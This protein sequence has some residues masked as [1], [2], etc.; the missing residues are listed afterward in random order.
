MKKI[1][2]LLL[3][4]L[5]LAAC[6]GTAENSQNVY[7]FI[8]ADLPANDPATALPSGGTVDLALQWGESWTATCSQD[9]LSLSQD[10]GD[11]GNWTL[12]LTTAPNESPLSREAVLT[13][14]SDSESR[15]IKVVQHANIYQ[16]TFLCSKKVKWS[17]SWIYSG[18]MSRSLLFMPYPQTGLYQGIRDRSTGNAVLKTSP[19]GVSYLVDDRSTAGS[20]PSSGSPFISQSF[21][22]DYYDVRVDFSLIEDAEAPYDQTSHTYKR[23]TTQVI[24]ENEIM[25]DPFNTTIRKT[26][27][28]LW[29]QAGG[30]RI[31]YA[32]L[33]HRWIIDN[34]SY[35]IF[36]D[37]NSISDI[38]NR[39]KG[40]CGNQ[41]AVWISLLRAKGIPARPIVMKAPDPEG[42]SHV[43][44]E[45]YIPGYG[46]IPV[47]P[48]NEQGTHE[49][50]FGAFKYEPLVVMNYDFGITGKDSK[51]KSYILG[52]LQG[53]A[54]LVWGGGTYD[55]SET[56][57]FID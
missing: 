27:Q 30:K 42:Y 20:F 1:L 31:E 48:T 57:Q 9:W 25:I 39:M 44:G 15:Q 7:G 53:M 52:L 35:A 40:D 41:H 45:F 5:T 33:C 55:G 28:T 17:F 29:E 24:D 34:I 56:F 32:R 37:H 21:T 22:V 23:Y 2:F 38:L 13:I 49:D 16:R 19:E 43:R 26:A 47:D 8:L 11:P 18:G 46:W 50:Y 3:A 4:T 12:Q 10:K 14:A 51:N 36:E 6:S 54:V